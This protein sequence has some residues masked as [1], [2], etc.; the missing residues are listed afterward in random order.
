HQLEPQ[1]QHLV[2]DLRARLLRDRDDGDRRQPLRPRP[3][4]DHAARHPAPER[5][6]DRGRHGHAEDGDA[7][8]AALRADGGAQVRAVDGLVR[9]QRRPVLAPRLSRA[10]GRRRGGAGRRLRP[11][12]PAAARGAALRPAEAAGEDPGGPRAAQAR[13]HG[14]QPGGSDARR[15]GR[16]AARDEGLTHGRGRDPPPPGPKVRRRDRRRDARRRHAFCSRRGAPAARGRRVLQA[17]PCARVRQPDVPLGRR[18]PEGDSAAPR[19][20]LPPLLA[21]PLPDLRAQGAPAAREPVGGVGREPVGRRELARAR[22]VGPLRHR[23]HRPQRPAADPAARR[24]AGAPAAQGLAGPRLLQRHARE[25]DRPDDGPRAPRRAD[26]RRP[27]RLHPAEPRPGAV[28]TSPAAGWA[29]DWDEDGLD[30]DEMVINMGPQHPATH[31]VLRLEL[32]TDGEVVRGARPHIGYLHRCFE[33]HAENVDYPGVMPYADRMDYVASMGN[34]LGFALTV[35]QLMG[36][37]PSPYVQT[38]RVLM[39]ELQR[40]ASHAVA[41]GTYTMDIGAFT[42]FLH[43]LRDRE[44][45]LDL[46]EWTC[47]ARLLYNYNWVG[48]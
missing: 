4:R 17:R 6:D 43:L 30:T 31:G 48:G 12:L 27:L 5:P 29:R 16:R 1:E 47:G 22:G 41:V 10:E 8:E 33:K 38:I 15:R 39:A 14:R 11:R 20:R 35:E 36:I 46:F 21:L 18:L 34:T 3:L 7:R 44:K 32:R 13:A 9:E 40:I 19:G 37:D 28:V 24:L 23:V 45:I 42:P 25:A 26:R 2:H